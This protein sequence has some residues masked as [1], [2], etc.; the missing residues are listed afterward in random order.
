MLGNL[1][2]LEFTM[3][4][5]KSFRHEAHLSMAAKKSEKM[6]AGATI[7]VALPGAGL[8]HILTAAAIY[9]ANASGKTNLLL[10]L[11]LMYEFVSESQVAW[12]PGQSIPLDQHIGSNGEPSN[13][14]LQFIIGGVRYRYGFK[15]TRTEFTEEWLSYYPLGRERI[16]F[17]RISDK[18]KDGEIQFVFGS[19]MSGNKRTLKSISQRVRPNSLFLSAGAQDNQLDCLEVYRWFA[20]KLRFARAET[21]IFDQ[22]TTSIHAWSFP[23]FKELLLPLI[24]LSDP[25]IEDIK[26]DFDGTEEELE[27]IYG[28]A[29]S[30]IEN[31]ERL[32]VIFI[33]KGKERNFEI[34]L[35][36]QSRGVRKLYELGALIVN[37][38]AFGHIILVDEL[39]SSMHPHVAAKILA[40]F[41]NRS[42]NPYRAQLVFTTHETRLLNQDHIRRDQIWF[43]EKNSLES[44]LFALSEFSPRKDENLETGYLRGRYG[45]VPKA[46]LDPTWIK[47]I[48]A[49]RT[50]IE[51]TDNE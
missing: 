31:S 32:K 17:K 39:E 4:N 7:P 37:S 22:T 29:E 18:S 16:I 9:G 41:Q 6:I 33:V 44:E 45:A 38:L 2:L 25:C 46:A 49:L 23:Q 40:L 42:S 13:F 24:K 3:S 21:D 1:M 20:N 12:K 19:K 11:N 27:T 10:G 34:P 35:R 36:N 43:C 51:E 26:V 50:K 30:I 8:D 48:S 15:A 28:N 14:E 47:K 5:F